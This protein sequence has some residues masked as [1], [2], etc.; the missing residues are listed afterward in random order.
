LTHTSFSKHEKKVEKYALSD[1]KSGGVKPVR[2][3]FSPP[4]LFLT[5][6]LQNPLLFLIKLKNLSGYTFWIHLRKR[7]QKLL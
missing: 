4:A 5:N 2:V 3:R 1:S 7:G 6:N